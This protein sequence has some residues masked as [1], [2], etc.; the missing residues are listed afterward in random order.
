MD[1]EFSP[2]SKD[3]ILTQEEE[4]EAYL[5]WSLVEMPLLAQ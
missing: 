4:P 3:S 1:Q 2:I 5:T